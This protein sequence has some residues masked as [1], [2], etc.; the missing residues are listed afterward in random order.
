MDAAGDALEEFLIRLE[1]RGEDQLFVA[2]EN[3]DEA[4]ARHQRAERA[5]VD[6]GAWDVLRA[7]D[8]AGRVARLFRPVAGRHPFEFAVEEDKA[9]AEVVV[10]VL[11]LRDLRIE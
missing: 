7:P 5:R 3:A 4:I 11:A 8:L 10:D 9:L 2:A 6:V 1:G